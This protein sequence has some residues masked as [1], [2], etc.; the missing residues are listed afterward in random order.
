M[1]TTVFH[2][3]GGI[4]KNVAAT[5]VVE[6]YKKKF[7]K[8]NIIV[9]SAWPDVW[10]RNTDIARF[11]RIG[12]TPYFYQDVIKDKRGVEV[13]M[14]CPYKQTSHITKKKHLIETWCDMVG[15]EYK[16]AVPKLDF[17][18]REIEEGAAYVSQFNDGQKP[19]LLFQPFG[20]PGPEHQQHPYSWARDMHPTQAQQIA[21]ALHEKFNIVHVCYEFHP[22]LNNVKRFDQMIG[23]KA[24][25]SMLAHTDK[26]ILIDSSLQHAAAALGLPSTVAWVVTH[27]DLFGYNIHNNVTTNK[28]DIKGTIDS[29]MHDHDFTGVIHECPFGSLDDFHDVDAIVKSVLT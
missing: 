13:F 29:Y 18:I 8:R 25:F 24:L 3:E 15:V 26:R 16:G 7:P 21:D 28:G 20:G 1:A 11:Y 2:I 5:A 12:N 9:V 19:M 14:Q 17:N 6:T 4:G 27:P 22:Q 23:K 10:T